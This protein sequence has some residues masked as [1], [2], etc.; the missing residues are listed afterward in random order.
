MATE[1]RPQLTFEEEGHKYFLDGV[2]IPSVTTVIGAV[3]DDNAGFYTEESRLR[4]T[5]VH[6]ACE[7]DDLGTLDES[8]LDEEIH[9]YLEG[10]RKFKRE[11]EPIWEGIECRLFHP[12][13]RYASTLDRYGSA[14][15]NSMRRRCV[16]EIKT[17]GMSPN[18]NIQTAAQAML[19]PNPPSWARLIIQL[20]DD[21]TYALQVCPT[22]E[23]MA[24][25]SVFISGLNILNWKRR[26]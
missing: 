7:L 5:V 10:Y 14:M 1:I 22:S 23:L 4:G 15:F 11:H 16:G 26:H 6:L 17:G 21:A 19:L 3:L 13:Y 20:F 12:H 24:D 2:E 9:P 25:F 8:A 18:Y